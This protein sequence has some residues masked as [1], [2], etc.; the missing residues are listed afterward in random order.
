[1][2][3]NE[4][5]CLPNSLILVNKTV[6]EETKCFVDE[7]TNKTFNGQRLEWPNSLTDAPHPTG[8]FTRRVDV[9]RLHVQCEFLLGLKVEVYHSVGKGIGVGAKVGHESEHCTAEGAVDLLQRRLSGVVDVDD[10]NVT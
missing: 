7:E 6:V 5:V 9:M 3:E 4:V 8:H 2:T 1:M 10:G